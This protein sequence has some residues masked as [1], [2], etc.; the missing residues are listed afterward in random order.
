MA[1]K[2]R[3]LT[4][5]A[6]FAAL[7]AVCAQLT[8]PMPSGVGFTLQTFA[9][10]LCGFLLGVKAGAAAM[11]AY[12][13]VGLAGAPVFSGFQ[14]GLQVLF[15]PTGGFLL[16]FFPMTALC[17]LAAGRQ[18]ALRWIW[19]LPGLLVCHLGGVVQFALLR[20]MEL[21]PAFLLVS[22]PFLVKDLLS[23]AAAA[24]LAWR[25]AP[26][27]ARYG[28]PPRREKRGHPVCPTDG[29]A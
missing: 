2:I 11:L 16:G 26:L 10:A 12:L 15:G 4:F 24:L 8:V 22:A 7:I 5:A 9:V 13:L 3:T 1:S 28:I 17:G 23:V 27:L 6:L 14:G 19:G 29:N 18:G 25:L 20:E 21:L